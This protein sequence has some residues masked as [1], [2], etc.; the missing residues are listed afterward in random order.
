MADKIQIKIDAK[1]FSQMFSYAHYAREHFGS[2]IAGWGHFNEKKG[3]YK[4]TPLPKQVVSGAEVDAFPDLILEDTSYDI[5]DMIVQWHSHVDMGVFFSGTDNNNIKDCMKIF[6]MLISVIVNCK[7]QYI[8]KLSITKAGGASRITLPQI[9]YDVELIPY[10]SDKDISKEVLAKCSRPKPIVH[11]N[12][13]QV[14]DGNDRNYNP[15]GFGFDADDYYIPYPKETAKLFSAKPE[16]K[17]L[18]EPKQI[19][20]SAYDYSLNYKSTKFTEDEIKLIR[21]MALTVSKE[22]ST[23][24]QQLSS[25]GILVLQATVGSAYLTL[26]GNVMEING[27]EGSWWRFMQLAHLDWKYAIKVK[28]NK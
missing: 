9:D 25:M 10:Y 23:Q 19:W 7:G 12:L 26:E 2:E 21:D 17:Q 5:S 16:A 8:A 1:V 22:L 18:E 27:Q 24:F 4:L 3:I 13:Y 14:S 6:P 15:Y 11:K 20:N 28:K